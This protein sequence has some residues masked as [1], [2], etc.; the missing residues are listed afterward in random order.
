MDQLVSRLFV[1]GNQPFLELPRWA[2]PAANEA[3][4]RFSGR[5]VKRRQT[6]FVQQFA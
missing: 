6:V 2:M 3:I 4:L 5:F 1:R